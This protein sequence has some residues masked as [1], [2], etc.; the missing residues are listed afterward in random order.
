MEHAKYATV[1][2]CRTEQKY[3]KSL[4][5]SMLQTHLLAFFSDRQGFQVGSLSH[6]MNLKANGYQELPQFPE[7]APDPSVRNVEVSIRCS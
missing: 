1:L 6:M 2:Q 7:V 5:L 4:K 3:G